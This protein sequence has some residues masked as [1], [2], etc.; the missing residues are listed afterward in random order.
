MLG[1][2]AGWISSALAYHQRMESHYEHR[3]RNC[4]K[5]EE[6]QYLQTHREKFH[7]GLLRF[8]TKPAA[9]CNGLL[10]PGFFFL[11]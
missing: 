3:V 7:E 5:K 4:K 11:H 8:C 1:T 10:C 6:N 9:L 2:V